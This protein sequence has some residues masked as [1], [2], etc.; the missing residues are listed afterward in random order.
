MKDFA[1]P[2]EVRDI[3]DAG[4]VARQQIDLS[5]KALESGQPRE[6][7]RNILA[8]VLLVTTPMMKQP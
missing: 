3:A 4:R 1:F 8:F 2:S 5:V 7:A 6:A